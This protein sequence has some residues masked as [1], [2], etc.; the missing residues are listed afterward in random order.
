MR[1]TGQRSDKFSLKG[2]F[3]EATADVDIAFMEEL[4]MSGAL[5]EFEWQAVNYVG[6]PD[7]KTFVGRMTDF[8]YER[9][10]GRHGQTP[11]TASFTREA[12]LG[13]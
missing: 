10:G 8:Q 7:S 2:S 5:V 11:Y 3:L 1:D 13:V 4:L 6:T 9:A 12:S